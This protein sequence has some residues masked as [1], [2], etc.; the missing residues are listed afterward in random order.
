MYQDLSTG[1]LYLDTRYNIDKLPALLCVDKNY[2]LCLPI[3]FWAWNVFLLASALMKQLF[4][5]TGITLYTHLLGKLFILNCLILLCLI[6]SC[7]LIIFVVTNNVIN[8]IINIYFCVYSRFQVGSSEPVT[9]ELLEL[10]EH[11]VQ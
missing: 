2:Q 9:T 8:F 11:N 1:V 6:S 7:F 5:I 3:C 4:S 10:N